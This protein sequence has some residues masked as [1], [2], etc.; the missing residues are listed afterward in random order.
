M[1]ACFHDKHFGF[2]FSEPDELLIASRVMC[3]SYRLAALCVKKGLCSLKSKKYNVYYFKNS[4]PSNAAGRSLHG[5]YKTD[6][7]Y[8]WCSSR[9]A[10]SE[11]EGIEF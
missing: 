8:F 9:N 5:R 10:A 1:H 11:E 6:R 3:I 2:Q 4:F 7:I